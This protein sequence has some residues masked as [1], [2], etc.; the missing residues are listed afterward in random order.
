MFIKR[1]TD[2]IHENNSNNEITDE[3]IT[4]YFQSLIDDSVDH[5]ISTLGGGIPVYYLSMWV[6]F[7]SNKREEIQ[8]ELKHIAE[9]IK[10]DYPNYNVFYEYIVEARHYIYMDTRK[11]SLVKVYF[12]AESAEVMKSKFTYHNSFEQI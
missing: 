4:D 8:E 7:S 3:Q 9:N 6:D 12:T 2:F 11:L 1:Y 5:A 10:L